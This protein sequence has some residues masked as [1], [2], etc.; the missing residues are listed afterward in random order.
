[1]K[2]LPGLLGR[3]RCYE[4]SMLANQP[5]VHH[6][7]T[8][9]YKTDKWKRK[10]SEKECRSLIMIKIHV[11]RSQ[12]EIHV[13]AEGGRIKMPREMQCS[14]VSTILIHVIGHNGGNAIG[15][16]LNSWHKQHWMTNSTY[17]N[18]KSP[19]LRHAATHSHICHML[20]GWII[21]KS[22]LRIWPFF[23]RCH[24]I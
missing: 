6:D 3:K 23:A 11:G 10:L 8:L 7:C 15:R 2:P 4:S 12:Q 20:F 24:A 19:H 5:A 18:C 14:W 22:C 21:F 1:M 16:T 17:G 9:P 13:V